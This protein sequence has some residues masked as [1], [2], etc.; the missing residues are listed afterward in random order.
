MII[1]NHE[2]PNDHVPMISYKWKRG[3]TFDRTWNAVLVD[4]KRVEKNN[5][6]R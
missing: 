3:M 5:E 6:L 2:K 1:P 4:E